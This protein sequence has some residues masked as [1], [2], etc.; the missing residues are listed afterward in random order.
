MQNPVSRLWHAAH[1]ALT[2]RSFTRSATATVA[3]VLAGA[4][5]FIAPRSAEAQDYSI[6]RRLPV[7]HYNAATNQGHTSH[8]ADMNNFDQVVGHV[9]PFALPGNPPYP[10]NLSA[11]PGN[12]IL[13]PPQPYTYDVSTE[14]ITFIDLPGIEP[15]SGLCNNGPGEIGY[16]R[17]NI[18]TANPP[19]DG[20][21]KAF[22][23][24]VREA[25]G[26]QNDLN[27]P[28]S[29]DTSCGVYFA[30]LNDDG[31]AALN[32]RTADGRIHALTYNQT[33]G[34]VTSLGGDRLKSFVTSVSNN[35]ISIVTFDVNGVPGQDECTSDGVCMSFESRYSNIPPLANGD[36][37]NPNRVSF[38]PDGTYIYGRIQKDEGA[39]VVVAAYDIGSDTTAYVQST[40]ASDIF[41]IAGDDAGRVIGYEARE[42]VEHP[43]TS[44]GFIFIAKPN[45]TAIPSP[46]ATATGTATAV[47]TATMTATAIPAT[48]TATGTAT[49]VPTA[50]V[51]QT[52][53]ASRTPTE[54]TASTPTE[55]PTEMPDSTVTPTAEPSAT[56]TP[57]E[58]ATAEATAT[59]TPC[60][61]PYCEGDYGYSGH[62]SAANLV[63]VRQV[64]AAAEIAPCDVTD[65]NP[66]NGEITEDV[67][68]GAV[69]HNIFRSDCPGPMGG[70]GGRVDISGPTPPASK[71]TFSG[72]APR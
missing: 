27:V 19:C 3:S 43:G 72:P 60:P 32:Y 52:R 58:T 10:D 11:V 30:D 53:T 29:I 49:A 70:V 66:K 21:T 9:R 16:V 68:V 8:P 69:I 51:T 59:K 25:D 13:L 63:R 57:M 38:S 14:V 64:Q 12:A 48:A 61:G 40:G 5:L 50:S 20:T 31:L 55:S 67:E 54:T 1:R 36:P 46:T 4:S 24:V 18:G 35:G 6:A 47:P 65:V 33:S 17:S 34:Q 39:P 71:A 23:F 37:D 22:T 45:P 2:Q 7:F 56:A 41:S 62:L 28:A 26:T 15:F 44:A 42:D